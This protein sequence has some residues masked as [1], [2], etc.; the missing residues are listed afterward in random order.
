VRAGRKP[1]WRRLVLPALLPALLLLLLLAALAAHEMRT[2]R[3][4]SSWLAGIGR[5]ISFAP[6]PGPS[7][8][9]HFPEGGP[10]DRRLGYSLLPGFV[11][12]L[13]MQGF[14]V[15]SQARF[16][17][18]LLDLTERGLFPAHREKTTAGLTIADRDGA[19]LIRTRIPRRAYAVFDS[20]PAVVVDMLLHVEN[21]ELL[22]PGGPRANPVIEWDRLARAALDWLI[23]KAV[24]GHSVP[25]ASS[26]ATQI[27]KFRHSP[28]GRTDSAREKLRQI[29]SASVR[30]YLDG[31]ETAGARRSIV[32]D[33]LD[34]TPLAGR[35]GYGEVIGMADGLWAWYGTE[36]EEANRLLRGLDKVT[37]DDP[38]LPE[39]A[40]VVK[41]VLSLVL[42]A[43]RPS[44]YLLDD[45]AGLD[46]LCDATLPRLVEAGILRPRVA[47]LARR[48]ELPFRVAAPEPPPVSH[49]ER[50]AAN[51]VRR[52]LL[53]LLG[54]TSYYD[55]DRLDLTVESTLAGA[56]QTDVS[57]FMAGLKDPDFARAAGFAEPRLLASG[58]PA[59]IIYSV[60]LWERGRTANVL[61]VQ[62]DSY[63]QP[64]DINEGAKLE[65]GSTAKL[66][67][68]AHY[69][70]IIAELHDRYAAMGAEELAAVVPPKDDALSRWAIAWLTRSRADRSLPA[71]LD[72]AMERTYSA[73]PSERFF[74]GGGLHTFGNFDPLD[75]GRT[76]TVRTALHESINLPFVRLLRDIVRYT[77]FAMPGSSAR[78][79]EDAQ[80]PA[81]TEYLLRFADREGTQFLDRFYR[82]YRS[83][84]PEDALETLFRTTRDDP[85]RL[86]VIYRSV[87]AEA[88]YEG[89][90]RLLADR[91]PDR[92]FSDRELKSLWESHAPDALSLADRGYI[93]RVHPLELWLVGFLRAHPDAVRAD[94]I[95]E[96]EQER[97]DVYRWLLTT[98]RRNAQD[99]KLRTMLEIEAFVEIHRAWERLD[100]PF[101]SLVP[102]LATALGSSGDRPAALAELAGII[103]SDGVRMPARRIEAFHFAEDTPYETALVPVDPPGQA[104]MRPEVAAVLKQDLIGVVRDGTAR[105][106]HGAFRT[107]DGTVI[108]V[109]GKTGTG[110]N[111]FETYGPSGQL[112][113][114]RVVSRVAAFVFTVG[115]RYFGVATAYVPGEQAARYGFTSTLTT[116]LV[117]SLAPALDPLVRNA[118]EPLAAGEEAASATEAAAAPPEAP[119]SES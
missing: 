15:A 37:D 109:G 24:P 114:S 87:V 76:V 18:R 99:Q 17:P 66:R 27:E 10:Y 60:T 95:R 59:E 13:E 108:P 110:D 20:V 101:R 7:P 98:K 43:R 52:R 53:P 30:A 102:S 71:M 51:A 118:M 97:R 33:Y 16:S 41:Q 36:V 70:A 14:T 81:R 21:R 78:I 25:G 11:A 65:L 34:S 104:A 63:D 44:G 116:Q 3:F 32:V 74:T 9:I 6:E 94:V 4:Q 111:R 23:A 31:E 35:P 106:V 90:V 50:K 1:R 57:R 79:L 73:S 83:A 46:D 47:A 119:P 96:S 42:A 100:Y 112:I 115:D 80:D 55:L 19:P 45:H 82:K 38:S 29:A 64:F 113:E 103:L 67:V 69:L 68:M 117:K 75:D 22:T 91:L 72:A 39:R 62:T 5:E 26:L 86:A 107:G 85:R 56:V 8:S 40:A 58:D 48:A 49:V 12:R 61:R 92:R 54:M 77:T 2:A 93:A 28:E 89:L 105:R 84:T 88:D